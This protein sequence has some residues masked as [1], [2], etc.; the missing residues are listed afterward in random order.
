MKHRPSN[1]HIRHILLTLHATWKEFDDP[2]VLRCSE[3]LKKV[4]DSEPDQINC[5]DTT[6]KK[7]NPPKGLCLEGSAG[8]S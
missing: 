6:L 5:Q 4:L 3:I 2:E 8:D 7:I 1:D